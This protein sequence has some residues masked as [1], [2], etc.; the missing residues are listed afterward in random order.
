[1]FCQSLL[2]Q[3]LTSI[4]PGWVYHV[5]STKLSRK[6]L[7]TMTV[8]HEDLRLKAST[9]REQRSRVR[10][11]VA[12]P[13]TARNDSATRRHVPQ[14]HRSTLSGFSMDVKELL[15]VD[16]NLLEVCNYDDFR[17]HQQ[18]HE[19]DTRN[20]LPASDE[21]LGGVHSAPN[22]QCCIPLPAVSN[23]W[24]FGCLTHRV[25]RC[26]DSTPSIASVQSS[27]TDQAV[28]Q[29]TILLLLHFLRFLFGYK[30]TTSKLP[31]RWSVAEGSSILAN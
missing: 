8:C 1:M 7:N 2:P 22:K 11:E 30:A 16:S 23:L 5:G 24:R 27:N 26:Q 31:D 17:Q 18:R 29:A 28:Q 25:N 6:R 19:F 14:V 10:C 15:C 3:L 20:R 12:G 4:T 21:L 9:S 13:D